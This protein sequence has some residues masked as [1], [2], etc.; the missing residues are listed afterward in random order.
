LISGRF[1]DVFRTGFVY[2]TGEIQRVIVTS[3]DMDI[4][5][6]IGEK[7]VKSIKIQN[8]R[9]SYGRDIG[10][11]SDSNLLLRAS[12]YRNAQPHIDRYT[13]NWRIGYCV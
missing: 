2:Y 8:V 9:C 7:N 6:M 11:V 13:T 12:G 1:K 5:N 4:K 10:N 3:E